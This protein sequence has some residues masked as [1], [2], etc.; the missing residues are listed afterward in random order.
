[1]GCRLGSRTGTAWWMQKWRL[2][3]APQEARHEARRLLHQH[4]ITDT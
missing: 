4:I 1:M 3:L 2:S